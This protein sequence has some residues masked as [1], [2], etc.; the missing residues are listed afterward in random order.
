MKRLLYSLF[1]LLVLHLPAT[2]QQTVTGTLTHDGIERD[3]RLRIPPAAQAGE[4]IPLVFNLHGF[5]SNAL[6]QEF[7]A[8][9]NTVAD[10]EGFFVCYANGIDVS[11]NV[12]WDFGSTA[13]DVGFISALIDALSEEYSID[14]DRVYS[15]G[16]SN[17]GFMSYRLA[18]ELNDRIAAVAS[19][20]GSMTPG[21]L[22]DC[23]PGRAVPVLEIHGTSDD[24]VGYN[25]QDDVSAGIP[26]VLAFWANNN[27]CDATPV[28]EELP[29]LVG[30]DGST[31]T[32][33]EYVNCDEG[34]DVLH[35]RVN[36]G[37]H[38]WPSAGIPIGPTNYDI[39]ASEEIWEFFS[40]YTLD[41]L[42]SST[43]ETNLL[44]AKL[45]PNPVG[46]L[47]SLQLETDR[48][49][50][51]VYDALGRLIYQGLHTRN[52]TLD[53]RQWPSG[54]YYLRVQAG[55]RQGTFPV[56]KQ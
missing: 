2:A 35:F 19:V 3:Y 34:I 56:F 11:W 5:G 38:T 20:T 51:V 54:V 40:R 8:A 55:D 30:T 46:S 50:V 32:R 31:V 33:I 43:V 24:V 14:L 52:S 22:G 17:G 12:G 23:E 45:F 10:A 39:D 7:Y 37:E 9:M 44:E 16:M 21:A 42:I 47:L 13:D 27:G 25:G 29:D 28:E 6:E 49:Q 1:G 36:G 53:T 18:C 26:E 48:N 41:G 4:T 15:C